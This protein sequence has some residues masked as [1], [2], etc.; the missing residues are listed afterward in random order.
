MC[1]LAYID[2]EWGSYLTE[3]FLEMSDPK[4][5]QT[6]VTAYRQICGRAVSEQITTLTGSNQIVNRVR[7]R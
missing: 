3:I 7:P 5:G 6:L 2:P 1:F 4:W